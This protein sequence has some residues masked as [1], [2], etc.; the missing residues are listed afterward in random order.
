METIP[1]EKVA[2]PVAAKKVG[3]KLHSKYVS[4]A[5]IDAAASLEVD[6]ESSFVVSTI[7]E[8]TAD[9]MLANV[10]GW[11][12]KYFKTLVTPEA[13]VAKRFIGRIAKDAAGLNVGVRIWRKA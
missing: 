13:P 12:N 2:I 5:Q 7:A 11:L 1:V 10:P 3:A 9:K 6:G 4:Q 8:S